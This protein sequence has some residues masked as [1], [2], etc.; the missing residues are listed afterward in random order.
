MNMMMA[1]KRE[2]GKI[3]KSGLEKN[4]MAIKPIKRQL[5]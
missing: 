4:T 5:I 3:K 2:R 1:L